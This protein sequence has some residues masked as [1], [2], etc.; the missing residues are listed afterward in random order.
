MA[1]AS[2]PA[3]DTTNVLKGRGFSEQ[4]KFALDET[5]SFSGIYENYCVCIV[6]AVN[7]TKI[8]ASLP[9]TKMC[10]YYGIFL[11]AM[12]II[13]R[14]F[15]GSVVKNVGDSLLYY[16][17]ETSELSNRTAFTKPL[18]CGI[19]MIEAHGVIDTKMNQEGLPPVD[20]RISADYGAVMTAKSVNSFNADLFG[21]TVNICS[22]INSQA[23]PNNMVVGGD[24]YQIVKS[25][26]EYHFEPTLSYSTGLKL[27]YPVYTIKRN[28]HDVH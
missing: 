15:G 26:T 11:N 1:N 6:D 19:A 12:A 3:E 24:L 20:Y 17:P 8:T 23:L 18:E 2:Y 21:S 16:F 28:N 10:K 13:V 22:K 7:S 4:L 9:K 14:E 5:I 25:F 27:Q